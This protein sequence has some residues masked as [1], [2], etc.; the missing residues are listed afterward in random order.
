MSI[1]EQLERDRNKRNPDKLKADEERRMESD[2][3]AVSNDI[4]IL[5]EEN[6]LSHDSTVGK[7]VLLSFNNSNDRIF[8]I[9]AICF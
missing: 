8:D 2:I 5:R 1:E 9:A 3:K 6:V 4:T 7:K